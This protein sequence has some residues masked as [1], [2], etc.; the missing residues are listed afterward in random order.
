MI[1]Y[2][3][4]SKLLKYNSKT[5]QLIWLVK[6]GSRALKGEIAGF[7]SKRT[8]GKKYIRVVI[9]DKIYMAHNII[10]LLKTK[11]LPKQQIDHID[12]CGTNN[13]WGNLRLVSHRENHKN[14]RKP[15]NNTSGVVGV[16]WTKNINK[17][18]AS[19]KIN[20]KKIKLGYFINKEDAVKSRK[21]AEI[22]YGFHSN[23]GE[24]RPL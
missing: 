21:L 4:V 3:E 18:E 6:K 16:Y 8:N 19:I 5:G 2:E 1:T 14:K 11:N 24:E 23:H 12:G 20:N 17:W 9:N 15:S 7:S 13:K 10:Y 22:Q